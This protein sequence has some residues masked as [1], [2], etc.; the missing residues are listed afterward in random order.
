MAEVPVATPT[1][2][3]SKETIPV[4]DTP[5]INSKPDA[6]LASQD[7]SMQDSKPQTYNYIPEK[8]ERRYPLRERKPP[9]RF[10]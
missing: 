9:Q 4:L 3:A 1:P 5:G 10:Y 2:A 6:T 8:P 7:L